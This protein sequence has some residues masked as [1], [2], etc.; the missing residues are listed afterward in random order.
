VRKT[1]SLEKTLIQ[2][3]IEDKSSRR[4]QRMRWLDDITDSTYMSLRKLREILK[5]R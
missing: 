2:E 4:Q 3:T 5:D 1:N